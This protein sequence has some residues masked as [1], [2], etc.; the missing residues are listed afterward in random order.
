MTPIKKI[1]A[2]TGSIATGKSTVIQYLKDLGY[3]VIDFDKLGHDVLYEENIKSKLVQ[4]FGKKILDGNTIDRKVLGDIVFGDPKNLKRL[5]EIVHPGI[6][7]LASKLLIEIKDPVLFL[8]IPLLFETIKDYP[9]FYKNI[10]EIWTV[11]SDQKTQ[12]KRLI[13][14]DGLSHR[15]ALQKINSQLNIKY[16]EDNSDVV[17]FNNENIEKLYNTI[18]KEVERIE[19]EKIF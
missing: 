5:N 18:D 8:E 16:K 19:S 6:F 1:V 11:S 4:K 12:L 15:A 14:R 3:T 2:I 17:I 9:E 10:S 13:S 7:D